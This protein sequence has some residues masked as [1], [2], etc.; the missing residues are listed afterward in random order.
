[1]RGNKSSEVHARKLELALFL[2]NFCYKR[3]DD[4]CRICSWRVFFC[5]SN[6]FKLKLPYCLVVVEMFNAQKT[7]VRVKKGR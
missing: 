1:M 3:N 7:K 6:L 2:S 5:L 4:N